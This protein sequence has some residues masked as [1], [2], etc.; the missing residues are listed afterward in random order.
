MAIPARR[1]FRA[2]PT[3]AAGSTRESGE[4]RVW[5]CRT[6]SMKGAARWTLRLKASAR[7][8]PA[9]AYATS[10]RCRDRDRRV[11]ARHPARPSARRRPG[12]RGPSGSAWV[13]P[14]CRCSRWTR[15]RPIRWLAGPTH[16]SG[17]VRL[18]GDS[19][20]MAQHDVPMA[21]ACLP[22]RLDAWQSSDPLPWR[23]TGRGRQ[24][25]VG[26]RPVRDDGPELQD[27]ERELALGFGLRAQAIATAVVAGVY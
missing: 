5:L 26:R 4:Y 9:S 1:A 24:D 2:T 11:E 22:R 27:I 25:H 19:I 15:P 8:I 14:R 16:D 7:G 10:P 17:P 6:R 23:R 18:F 3:S 21:G 13:A 12:N 20:P